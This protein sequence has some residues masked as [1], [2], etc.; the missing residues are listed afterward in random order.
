MNICL[1]LTYLALPER[2]LFSKLTNGIKVNMLSLNTEPQR[3]VLRL[4][5]PGGR[6][7]ESRKQPGAVLVGSRTIQ[8]GGA[9][10][11]ITREDV[12]LFCI[13][14]LL[15]VDITATEEALIFDVS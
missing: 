10:L 2:N 15:M 5:V 11:D 4:Y 1:H 8:E 12:E 6:M 7:R 13:D 14:H 9:F 3:A